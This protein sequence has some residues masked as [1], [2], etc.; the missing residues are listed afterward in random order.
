MPNVHPVFDLS[1][2]FVDA[3]ARSQPLWATFLGISGHD[4][5]WG[6]LGPEGID[7]LEELLRDTA[8]ELDALPA[9][10]TDDDELAI[11]VLGDIIASE[12]EPVEHDDHLRDISHL[13][14]T[15]L[16]TRDVLDIQDDT[17]PEGREALLARL[18]SLPDALASWQRRIELALDRGIVV[19]QRQ[20]HSVIE[21]L[22][23]AA[24]D[25]GAF[26]RRVASLAEL[27]PA[28]ADPAGATLPAIRERVRELTSFLEHRYLPQAS[29][30]DA[31][32]PERYAREAERHVGEPVDLDEAVAWAW[33]ELVHLRTRA[34][35][36]ATRID[37]AATL[38]EVLERLHDDPAFGAPDPETFRQLMQRRQTTAL[39]QLADTRFD[40]PDS[41]RHVE[42]A[43]A[44]PGSPIGAQYVG[45]SEDLSR[46]GRIW[47]SL[48]DHPHVPLFE[49][50]ST[51]YHEGFPGHHLQLGF[52]TMHTGRLSRAHRLLSGTTGYIEGW[53]LYAETLMDEFGALEEPQ[54]E[55]GYITG[56]LLRVVRVL[57]DIGLHLE[58]RI[59]DDAP[60]HPGEAWTVPLA[61]EAL[62]DLAALA[63]AYARSEI[64]RY[65]GWPGQA[66]S[67]SLGQRTFLELRDAR[68]ARD[69]AA[70]DEVGFH[71]DVLGA[72]AIRLDHL[73]ELVLR[74]R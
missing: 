59:P 39:E 7:A 24:S 48:A 20:V 74:E 5:E 1:D 70:F 51:A 46:P 53:A 36:V 2:R 30:V 22:R 4:H 55:L 38:P 64:T 73:R 54:Y 67:Y 23:S 41:I 33:Q 50:V 21:Q 28:L 65:L 40:V 52:Q 68:R 47:W 13:T 37:P 71:A 29:T 26:A 27:D 6:D 32:G 62:T 69:G 8:R 45:P 16:A 11:R 42:V 44:P 34:E 49:E 58:Q 60:F 35:Q 31:V 66:I 19:A 43:L 56:Q 12:L 72:G 3:F 18:A 10:T 14:S 57:V 17:T 9:A 25:D 61:V 63:P 15:V